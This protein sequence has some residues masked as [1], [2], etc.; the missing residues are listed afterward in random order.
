ML[1]VYWTCLGELEPP[2]RSDEG[3]IGDVDRD[4]LLALGAQAVGEERE[5]DVLVAAAA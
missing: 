1:R 2:P 3:A 4:P 5:I